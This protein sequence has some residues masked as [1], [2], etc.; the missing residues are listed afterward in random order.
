MET[1]LNFDNTKKVTH[2]FDDSL[3]GHA[4]FKV[5]FGIMREWDL[6]QEELATLVGRPATTISEWKSKES[7][8]ISK[9]LSMNDYQLFT[10]IELY[11]ALTNLFVLKNDRVS[12]LREKNEGLDNKSPLQIIEEDPRKLYDIK[13]LASRLTNP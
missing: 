9:N 6:T 10:F 3:K 12:W 11:K 7:I 2:D 4:L 1:T 13:D 8:P 5:I